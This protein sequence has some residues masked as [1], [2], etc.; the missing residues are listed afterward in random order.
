[1]VNGQARQLSAPLADRA[2]REV[3][4]ERPAKRPTLQADDKTK[5]RAARM[6]GTLLVGTLQKFQ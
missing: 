2:P 5:R 4:E 6:F 1:M 3:T